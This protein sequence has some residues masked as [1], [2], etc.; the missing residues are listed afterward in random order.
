MTDYQSQDKT[1]VDILRF[2]SFLPYLNVFEAILTS[3]Q[4]NLYINPS[5][6]EVQDDN[7]LI[8]KKKGKNPTSTFFFT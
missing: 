4:R 3:I 2:Y 1:V 7:K 5:Q 6:S 8:F